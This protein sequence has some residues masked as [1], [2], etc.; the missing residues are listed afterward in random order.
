M[1]PI[2]HV[3]T[4]ALQPLTAA[5]QSLL[6]DQ[7]PERET[8][9]NPLKPIMDEYVPEKPQEPSGGYWMG[10]DE[11]GQPKIYFDSPDQA[12]DAPKTPEDTP[13]AQRPEA[14][15]IKAEE[16]G[17]TDKGAK[18]LKRKG[19]S[20]GEVCIGNTDKA[21]Q[22]IE[23]LKKKLEKLEQCL[24]AETDEAKIKNLERQLAQVEQELRQKDNDTYRK[25]HTQFS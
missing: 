13:D 11:N 20:K 4:S 10:R 24:N 25:Q 2:S 7:K 12:A 19:G 3:N 9:H 5:E 18:S 22:E 8:Q 17:Q 23:K 16:P 15:A 6:K 21:D 14:D 1:M